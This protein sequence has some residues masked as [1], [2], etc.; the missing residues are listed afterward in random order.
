MAI[1]IRSAAVFVPSP[2]R[3]ELQALEHG[4]PHPPVQWYSDGS[5]YQDIQSVICGGETMMDRG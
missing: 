5:G 4:E 2:Y 3:A 1:T